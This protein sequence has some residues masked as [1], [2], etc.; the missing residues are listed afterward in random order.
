M[1]RSF[2]ACI[3][4]YIHIVKARDVRADKRYSKL[5]KQRLSDW[6]T[7]SDARRRGIKTMCCR[8]TRAGQGA[9]HQVAQLV[10]SGARFNCRDCA[11]ELAVFS[12][13]RIGIDIDSFDGFQG[14]SIAGL[15]VTGSVTLRLDTRI[16]LVRP[17]ALDVQRTVS[18]ARL[19]QQRQR[20]KLLID[21][22]H[23]AAPV[24][25]PGALVSVFKASV[26]SA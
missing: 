8:A 13:V 24:M 21:Q 18:R 6:P 17:G 11:G 4:G 2:R 5:K 19:R 7:H 26:G 1:N 22:A 16:P 14:S 12:G 23:L 25:T 9:G 10:C 3:A 15:P 20:L